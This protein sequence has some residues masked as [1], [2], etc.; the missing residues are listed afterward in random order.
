MTNKELLKENK[1]CSQCNKNIIPLKQFIVKNDLIICVSCDHE[2]GMKEIYEIYGT[3]DVEEIKWL[4]R[5]NQS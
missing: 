4:R 1:P 2:N 5:K 3:H